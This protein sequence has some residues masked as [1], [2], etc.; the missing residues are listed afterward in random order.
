MGKDYVYNSQI[1]EYHHQ[2]DPSLETELV[3]RWFNWV[4]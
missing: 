1:N 2:N 4:T 3:D